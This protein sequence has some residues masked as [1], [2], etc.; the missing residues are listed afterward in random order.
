MNG[1]TEP[2]EDRF[3]DLIMKGG[4][5]SGVVYPKAIDLLAGRY[6]FRSIGG[7]SAGAIA[8]AITAAAEFN[9]RKTNTRQGFDILARLPEELQEHLPGTKRSRLLSLFQAQ[10]TTRR[11]FSTLVHSLNSAGTVRR[12]GA[13][14]TGLLRAYW[15]ATM[16]SLFAAAAV[17]WSGA[18]WLAAALLLPLALASTIG[19]WVYLDLTRRVV[20]NGF[21]MCNGLTSEEGEPALTPWL[22]ALIQRAAGL[23]AHDPPLTFGMLWDAPGF[24]PPWMKLPA[25]SNLRSIDLQMFS[26]NLGHGR[27]YIFPL[28]PDDTGTS[29]FRTRER[30][31]FCPVELEH[32]LPADV[33]AWMTS[34]ARPYK[35]EPGRERSDP[36]EAEAI[37]SGLLELPK[38]K[39]FPVILAARMSLS[40]PLLLSAVPLWSIDY[41]A[42]RPERHFRRCWFSDG[43]ISSNFP[44]HLFDDLVP[45]WPTFGINLEP[46]I[47]GRDAVFLPSDYTEGYGERWNHFDERPTSASRFGGFVAAIVQTMQNWNDNSL[48]RMPGFRDRI[49]RVRLEANEGGLNLNMEPG[50][51]TKVS[52]LGE[53][54]AKEI[55]ARFDSTSPA[56]SASDGWDEQRFVRLGILLKMIEARIVGIAHALD[57]NCPYVTEFHTLIDR[58]TR[59]PGAGGPHPAPPGYETALTPQQAEELRQSLRK[60]MLFAAAGSRF[61]TDFKPMPKPEL[62]IRPPL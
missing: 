31:F 54:A 51:I 21:G 23:A 3:C 61:K 47:Q 49:A 7:T 28:A 18:G 40:F 30:L 17:F 62:R 12:I 4:L 41:D 25:L 35:M 39:D 33:C 11:L 8:A 53:K 43:G 42:P 9:R 59:E 37:A 27:P 52:A 15:P 19:T 1:S 20:E 50:V 24:P 10:P 56:D 48:S 13:I 57:P 46:K 26:T 2:P 55:L 60:L 5:T 29:R 22:H 32:Y 14:V 44:M 58:A 36:A 16:I 38:P 34:C 6:R 45:L